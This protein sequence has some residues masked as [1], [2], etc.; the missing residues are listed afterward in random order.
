ML[1][2]MPPHAPA[3][4]PLAC[5]LREIKTPAEWK[6][7]FTL[8]KQQNKDMTRKE[9][10]TLLAEMRKQGYRCVG[11]YAQGALVGIMGFWIGYRFWCHKYIDIDNVVVEKSLRSRGIGRKMLAWVEKEAKRQNCAMAVLDSYTTGHNAHRFYFREGYCIL[12][13]HFTKHL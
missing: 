11:A 12:G 1:P 4:R 9:F 6:A 5:T 10:E 2:A 3:T 8:V 13:Y 7:I